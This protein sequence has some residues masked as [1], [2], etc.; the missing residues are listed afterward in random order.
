MKKRIAI[1]GSTGSIGKSLLKIID[2]DK[3]NFQ[4]ILIFLNKNYLGLLAQAKKYKVKNLII[5]DS[6]SYKNLK[7]TCKKLNINIFNN[8]NDLNKIIKKKLDYLMN[9]ITGIDGLVPIKSIK[10]TKK[11]QL[12]IKKLLFVD[13]I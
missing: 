1:L 3:K 9:S 7:Y 5:T 12:Q 13:G 6:K 8:F 11:S 4:I 10:F 2:K